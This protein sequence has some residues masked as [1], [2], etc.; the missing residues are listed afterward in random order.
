ML[1][2]TVW[3]CSGVVLVF[4]SVGF[5]AVLMFVVFCVCFAVLDLR[6][7]FRWFG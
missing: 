1:V 7:V 3:G 4:K 2:W 6:Y 5:D